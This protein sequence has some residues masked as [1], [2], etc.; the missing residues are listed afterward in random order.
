MDP[1]ANLTEMLRSTY[2]SRATAP[3]SL[4]EG[5]SHGNLKN[6]VVSVSKNVDLIPGD[7][8]LNKLVLQLARIGAPRRW[9]VLDYLLKPLRSKYNYILL[10]VPPTLNTI[11]VDAIF[12]SDGISIVLQTQKMAYTSAIKT[13]RELFKYR[14]KY[15]ARFHFL[16]VILYLL[17]K[18]K[19]DRD[20]VHN[21]QS[22]FGDAIF[23][24]PIK[25]Q[26]RVKGF[27]ARG[28][29]DRDH[30]DVRAIGNYNQVN[31]EIIS[32]AKRMID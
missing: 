24:T 16:G 31:N 5:V 12:A 18:A 13:I 2:H 27:T 7:W 9:K 20:V 29:K 28:I 17:S 14:N 11:V 1:Q 19:V 30:W 15:H 22:A 21:A 8:N 3:V 23:K 6:T 10:D 4:Y 32:T 26:E 25:F